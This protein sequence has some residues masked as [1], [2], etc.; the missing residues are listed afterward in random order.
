M[1]SRRAIV[2]TTTRVEIQPPLVTTFIDVDSHLGRM[3]AQGAKEVSLPPPTTPSMG[4]H[5]VCH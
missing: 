1:Y 3:H 2:A 5:N 4:Q